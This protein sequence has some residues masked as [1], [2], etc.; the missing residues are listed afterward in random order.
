MLLIFTGITQEKKQK[1]EYERL[2]RNYETLLYEKESIV[3][4]SQK[5]KVNDSL[6]A[7]KV[8]QLELTLKEYK[9]LRNEDLKLIKQLKTKGQELQATISIKNETINRLS[10]QLVDSL[11]VG[12]DSN[13]VML[14]CFN[15]KSKWTDVSGCISRDTI[16][17]QINNRE[18]LKVVET[19]EYKR[20][21]GFLWKTNKIKNKQ[22]HILSENPNTQ[23]IDC[24]YIYVKQ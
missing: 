13:V 24:E 9:K 23:I 20:F 16:D 14:K 12:A 11:V 18:S 10:A 21:L 2:K 4:E 7:I 19:I 17:L 22:A 3:A 8:T 5:Y 15:Y 1:Q 6:N